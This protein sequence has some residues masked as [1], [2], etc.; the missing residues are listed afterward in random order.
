LDLSNEF[1]QAIDRS[2]KG[3]GLFES[4]GD[5]A[6]RADVTELNYQ[7]YRLDHRDRLNSEIYE[8]SQRTQIG[9]EK[10]LKMGTAEYYEL[11][12]S[13]LRYM[14]KMQPKT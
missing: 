3:R 2:F 11:Y 8:M 13:D 7:K 12:L 14:K 5:V 10:L 9:I 1:F 6:G 4:G